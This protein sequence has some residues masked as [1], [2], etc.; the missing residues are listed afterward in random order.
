LESGANAPGTSIRYR[1]DFRVSKDLVTQTIVPSLM[2]TLDL[3]TYPVGKGVI[4]EMIHHR[5]RHKREHNRIKKKSERER[6]MEAERKHRNSRRLEV[7]INF[8]FNR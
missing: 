2:K 4:Y 6:K 3:V 7:N 8:I 1:A 5:H